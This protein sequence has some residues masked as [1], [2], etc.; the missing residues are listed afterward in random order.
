ME[1]AENKE[2]WETPEMKSLTENTK[3]LSSCDPNQYDLIFFVGGFGTMW[4]FPFNENLASTA[5]TIYEKGGFVGAVCHGPI[6]L[7]NIKLS[8]GSY[9]VEGKEV[10]AFC[11]EEETVAGLQQYLPKH[12]SLGDAATCEDILI[13]RGAKYTK[14]PAWGCHI[15]VGDRVFTGQNPASAGAVA[16]A[17]VAAMQ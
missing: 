6:A 4:D 2:F 10:A 1:D 8:S 3:V 11:N 9:L 14:G 15:A 5:A 13:A 17:I 12:A 16:D 7:A